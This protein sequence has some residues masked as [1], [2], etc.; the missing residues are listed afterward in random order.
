[1]GLLDAISP[2]PRNKVLGLLSDMFGSVDAYANKP[3]TGMPMGKANPVLGLL[4]DAFGI[5]GTARTLDRL[6]YGEPITNIGKANVPLIPQDTADAAML[7]AAAL[8]M[9]S[10]GATKAAAFVSDPAVVRAIAD[11]ASP[12]YASPAAMGGVGSKG[13]GGMILYHGTNDPQALTAIDPNGGVFGGLFTSSSARSANSHGDALYRFT[14]PDERILTQSVIDELDG[15]KA[16]AD[17]LKKSGVPKDLSSMVVSA[18]SAF[19]SDIP[20]D[21]LMKA[22]RADS[23]GEAD[24]ELQRLRGKMAKNLGFN[25][26]EMPD[27]HGTSYLIT[28]G[29]KPRPANEQAKSLFGR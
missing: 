3:Q 23:I 17:A 18:K 14:V 2:T 8:P 28:G 26:V 12:R 20:E 24:W 15:T 22:L 10:R 6:S 4:S 16:M 25:A 11:A 13:Q 21:V 29:A 7:G 1:M 5:G 27:E 19:D 9:L